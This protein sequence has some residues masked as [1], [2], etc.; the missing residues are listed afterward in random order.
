MTKENSKE[1]L[2][3]LE[4]ASQINKGE[5]VSYDRRKKEKDKPEQTLWKRLKQ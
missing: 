5:T 3:M 1:K 2:E 4:I